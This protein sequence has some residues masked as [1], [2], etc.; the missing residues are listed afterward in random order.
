[1]RHWVSIGAVLSV[2]TVAI[3]FWYPSEPN[4]PH[5]DPHTTTAN[6][7]STHPS[8]AQPSNQPDNSAPS[9]FAVQSNEVSQDNAAPVSVTTVP[10]QLSDTTNTI[11]TKQLD[12][13]R[14]VTTTINISSIGQGPLSDDEFT[15][16]VAQLKQDPALL[17]QLIDEFRQEQ[18]PERKARLARLMGQVGGE[19]VLLAAS[20]LIYSGDAASRTLG[21]DLLQEVQPGNATARDIAS[22]LLSTEVESQVLIDTMTALAQPGDVDQNSRLFLADQVALLA[23]HDDPD[24]RG[25]SL[26][27]LSRWSTDERYT[28]V[29]LDGLEDQVSTVRQSAA[30]A[31]VGHEDTSQAVLDSL[32]SVASNP[33]ES[34]RARRGSLL[35]L[36]SMSISDELRQQLVIITRELDTQRRTQ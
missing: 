7:S 25:I 33:D 19:Q 4:G 23:T 16:I 3:W 11:A 28:Q 13:A 32:L 26:N 36:R 9:P 12:T 18:Q 8:I 22:S 15:Q 20:E 2:L 14:T 10:K 24:V 1:M 35:A 6:G 21:L 27:I 31:L 30:Y 34:K 17:S 29:L 5:S